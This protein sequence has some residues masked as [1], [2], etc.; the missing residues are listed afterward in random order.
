VAEPRPDGLAAYPEGHRLRLL[1]RP[2]ACDAV[3]AAVAAPGASVET[4]PKR[5]EDA[6]FVLVH[7]P[8]AKAWA[9]G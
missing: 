8:Q 3:R 9:Q 2:D 4:A 6:A 1:A 7:E 5:L